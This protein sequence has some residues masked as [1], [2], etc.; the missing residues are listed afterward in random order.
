MKCFA[1][2][3][4]IVLLTTFRISYSTIYLKAIN[5]K[6]DFFKPVITKLLSSGA[7]SSFV[8]SIISDD[9]TKFEDRYVKINVIGY[10]NKTDYSSAYNSNAIRE[11]RRFI[12]NNLDLLKSAEDNSGVS[13][14]VIA[15][16]LWIETKFGKFTGDN[17]ILSVFLS[18]A[19]ADQ[20]QFIS[21]NKTTLRE[22]YSGNIAD[23]PILEKKID[24][25]AK[26]KSLWAIKELLSLNQM[27]RYYHIAV[28]DIKG[29]W[30][31][32]FG[33]CQFLPSSYISWAVDGNGD[34]V[35]DLFDLD[36]A[37]F[38]IANY[39]KINGWTDAVEDKRKA[40]FHYNNSDDYVD[41]VLK[42]ADKVTLSHFRKP[43]DEQIEEINDEIPDEQ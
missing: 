18:T 2:T 41:A 16:I 14:E 42:L 9:N 24:E 30:A 38:S 26:K 20:P 11:T 27:S 29:S 23:I 4:L 28:K 17:Q 40:V 5:S 37:V 8:Y 1:L 21:M 36:D 12:N 15:A 34:G 35:I 22:K 32:A 7:D 3:T 31:G 6:I 19:M 43:V 33:L 39:L 25:R 10:L 13:K